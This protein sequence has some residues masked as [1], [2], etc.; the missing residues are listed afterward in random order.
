MLSCQVFGAEP[1][2]NKIAAV[3]ESPNHIRMLLLALLEKALKRL[4]FVAVYP[5][6]KLSVENGESCTF[7]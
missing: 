6:G 1:K 4:N 7:Y 3:R 5:G 2:G